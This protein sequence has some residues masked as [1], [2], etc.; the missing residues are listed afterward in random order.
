M[1]AEECE[2]GI[3][4]TVK[5]VRDSDPRNLQYDYTVR[6]VTKSDDLR[7]DEVENRIYRTDHMINYDGAKSL[8]GR[9]TRIW[10]VHRVVDETVDK[11]QSGVLKDFW[12]DDDRIPET[13][14]LEKIKN[15]PKLP[16]WFPKTLLT[17]IAT[18]DVYINAKRDSTRTLIMRGA[19]IPSDAAVF[20]TC[21]PNTHQPLHTVTTAIVTDVNASTLKSNV[22]E[23]KPKIVQYFSKYH[24]RI[25]FV[26][27]CRPLSLSRSLREV[28]AALL[29]IIAGMLWIV[30]TYAC[31][32][33]HFYASVGC[34]AYEWGWMGT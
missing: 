27:E 6:V 5:V 32:L 9:G 13:E 11:T 19:K 24:H 7:D 33:M 20:P 14:I 29:R 21:V 4:P 30:L 26:E 3:D 22:G 18:G 31:L 16:V 12:V 17:P 1:Y 10:K 2:L 15:Q 8:R 28:F 23:E 34:Y 25:V